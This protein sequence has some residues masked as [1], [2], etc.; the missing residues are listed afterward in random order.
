MSWRTNRLMV[1][2]RNLGRAVGLNRW[3][4]VWLNGRG[5]ETRYDNRFSATLQPGDCAW[6]VGANVGYYTRLFSARV[7]NGGQVCAFEPSP[8]NFARLSQACGG[9]GNVWMRQVGLGRENGVLSFQQGT[10][11]LGATSRVLD[12]AVASPATDQTMVDIRAGLG[13]IEA[14]EATAPNAIKIDVEGYELE[15]LQGLGA[16][17]GTPSLRAIGVEVHFGIL[18]ERGLSDAPQQ[19]ERLL[20]RSGFRVQWPDSSHLLATRPGA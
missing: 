2:A 10:D 16:Y 9:L 15:V 3:I 17:L 5:Y 7:G 18:K 14:G 6:D 19:I 4:A 12:A 1:L 20:E 11:E 8:A 13:L